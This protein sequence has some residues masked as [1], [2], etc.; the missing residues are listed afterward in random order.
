MQSISI[1][2]KIIAIDIRLTIKILLLLHLG[3][4]TDYNKPVGLSAS[5][6]AD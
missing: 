3:H 2:L 6:D 4:T 1:T 5:D